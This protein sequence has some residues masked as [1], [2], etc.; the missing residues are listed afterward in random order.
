M[1]FPECF[2]LWQPKVPENSLRQSEV[3]FQNEDV[4]LSGFGSEF[5]LNVERQLFL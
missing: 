1:R 4:S 5:K 2:F 3:F